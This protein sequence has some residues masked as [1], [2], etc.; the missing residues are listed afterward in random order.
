MTAPD[1]PTLV[2]V[3][4]SGRSGTSSL[5]GSLKRLGFHV[6]Q[7]EV[8]ATP[9]NPRGYYEP[10]WVIRF[11]K[12][13]LKQLAM[14]NIDSRPA[15]VDAVQKVIESGEPTERLEEW[16]GG[17]L[18]KSRLVVKDPHAFW[19]ADVWTAACQSLGVDLR[20]LTSL[21]HPAEVVGSRDLAYLQ[22]KPDR[23]RMAKETSNVAGWVHAALLTEK[24]GRGGLRSFIRYTDLIGDWR[25]A[26]EPVRGQLSLNL[27]ADLTSSEH[28]DV[29]DF[30]ETSLRRSQLTW[31][32]IRVPE[33]LRELAEEVWQLLGGLVESPQEQA[34]LN[35][36]DEIHDDYRRMYR[37]AAALTLDQQVARAKRASRKA[38][39]RVEREQQNEI[40]TLRQ[41]VRNKDRRI[42]ELEMR[43][44][45]RSPAVPR[46]RTRLRRLAGRS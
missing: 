17:Q 22:D 33:V 34:T 20:W 43:L 18:N 24:A 21:R 25:S 13:Y 32:D 3:S 26:L 10:S 36:L 11:H 14:H 44:A 38:E 39:R 7:P 31:E 45:Q 37:E 30:L 27:D 6:P 2:L 4:G 23:V 1:R 42:E 16:L 46:L 8:Q 15:A 35:R 5:A 19:F 12:G 9:E 41:R 40:R 28:H 29:D